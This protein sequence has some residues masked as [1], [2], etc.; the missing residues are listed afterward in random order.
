MHHFACLLAF[1]AT[2]INP[3]LALSTIETLK[4][5]GN[6][7]TSLDLQKLQKNYVKSVND[8]LLKIFSK[9]GISTLQSYHGSQ[10]FEI[11]GI[12]QAVVDKYFTGAVT[13]IGG[14][15]LDEIARES[16]CKHKIG[17]GATS[18]D[19][20]LPEGG[21]YQW[22]RR[23]ESHLFNPTTV[24]LLQHATRSN[25][26]PVYKNY[27]KEINEQSEKH[28]TIRGLLDFAHHREAIS[29]DE[30]E[31]AENIMKR[32][33]TGAMSFGS[34]SHEAHSTM[35]I[36]MNRIGGKSNTGEGGEDEFRYEQMANGDSMRSAIKQVA[37]ARFGVTSN[38]LSNAD[39]LQI[40]MAQGAKPGEGGQLPGHK[41][42]DWIAKTRHSTPGVGLISR[43]R[44][45]TIF[46]Q[47]KI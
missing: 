5:N 19:H 13:R 45:T 1:G 17:F 35:A 38:Y 23:G 43:P 42:D 18:A 16:L 12:N 31:P 37:S 34:I 7:E 11:L 3:Y 28:F 2:A 46:I 14:L 40:K 6:L 27:A 26:Y 39:E 29:I 22:K 25:S 8:G 21:I 9:M 44:P 30:V 47:L 20:L 36:A 41:V 32:F 24:H 4:N 15:G 10:V 33:A